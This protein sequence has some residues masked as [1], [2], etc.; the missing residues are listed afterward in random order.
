MNDELREVCLRSAFLSWACI[1]TKRRTWASR[2]RP[3]CHTTAIATVLKTFSKLHLGTPKSNFFIFKAFSCWPQP[4]LQPHAHTLPSYILHLWPV[5]PQD[6]P[7]TLSTVWFWT[8]A[9]ALHTAE[10]LDHPSRSKFNSPF[11]WKLTKYSRRTIYS[12][13]SQQDLYPLS[14]K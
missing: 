8:F 14:V 10:F 9:H 12:L 13:P 4:T 3:T 2:V 1:C 6:S 5:E 7:D 11:L